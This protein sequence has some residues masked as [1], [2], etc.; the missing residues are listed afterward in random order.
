MKKIKDSKC[1]RLVAEG[2]VV[3]GVPITH[4]DTLSRFS[5]P[6]QNNRLN[7]RLS[8]IFGN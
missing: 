4:V 8:Y 2:Q 5:S 7:K 6:H 1:P 3:P